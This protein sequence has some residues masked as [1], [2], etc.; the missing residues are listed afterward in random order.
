MPSYRKRYNN[1]I[2][3]A[4]KRKRPHRPLGRS[5]GRPQTKS[6]RPMGLSRPRKR[7][8]Y[9]RVKRMK[10]NVS[11]RPSLQFTQRVLDVVSAPNFYDS[12]VSTAF[13]ST[14]GNCQYCN[15][16][17]CYDI[18][19]LINMIN[20]MGNSEAVNSIATPYTDRIFIQSCV[21]TNTITNACNSTVN[22][23]FYF[24]KPRRDVPT[25][26]G[27][28][29]LGAMITGWADALADSSSRALAH[30]T[31]VTP[32]QSPLFTQWYKVTKKVVARIAPGK[33]YRY[34]LRAGA[35]TVVRNEIYNDSAQA[36]LSYRRASCC[37]Y[38][39]YG[40][41][42]SD[43]SNPNQ[44]SWGAVKVVHIANQ[45]YSWRY[46]PSHQAHIDHLDY[47]PT[48]GGSEQH[49]QQA[50]PNTIVNSLFA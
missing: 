19:D 26:I 28:S 1:F 5:L 21:V 6:R 39:I 50:G 9:S 44:V 2:A 11:S 34:V 23:E 41:P 37:I 46:I 49:I 8:T 22:C 20:A 7:P 33:T 17:S 35:Q 4:Q 14:V 30:D 18:S 16:I 12:S 27:S 3:K 13:A 32:F 36:L 43:A 45:R 29:V 42:V 10:R 48:F 25:A 24:F 15:P 47:L 38:K 31:T 40:E